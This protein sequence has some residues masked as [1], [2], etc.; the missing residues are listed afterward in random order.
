MFSSISIVIIL[1]IFLLFFM[2]YK[3]DMLI[4]MLSIDVTSS[5][6][7]FQ[8]QLEQTADI[9][10]KRL[11]EQISHLEYLL[12]EANE[13]IINLDEKI[14]IANKVLKKEQEIP[15]FEKKNLIILDTTIEKQE[16]VISNVITDRNT[17]VNEIETTSLS[18]DHDKETYI[19]HTDK[20]SAIIEMAD[21]GYDVTEIAKTTGISKGEIILLLQLNK[22]IFL[23]K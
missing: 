1:F 17:I 10:I 19:M 15:L 14:Q 21:L 7:R 3:R 9:I 23:K 18:S 11:E 2:F 8:Q 5:T 20:R 16:T 12:E 6:D 13:K 4:K 22:N